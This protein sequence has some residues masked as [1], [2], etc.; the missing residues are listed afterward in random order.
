MQNAMRYIIKKRELFI[1][2][3][4]NRLMTISYLKH[5]G[6][7][8]KYIL[9][10]LSTIGIEIRTST[11]PRSRTLTIQ[12]SDTKYDAYLST[13]QMQFNITKVFIY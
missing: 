5:K 10:C 9:H 2:S 6:L 1:S 11:P 13:F 3:K 7:S 12:L 8:L 4:I